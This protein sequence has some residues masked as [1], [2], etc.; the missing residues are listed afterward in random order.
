MALLGYGALAVASLL[1]GACVVGQRPPWANCLSAKALSGVEAQ[2]Q[3]EA[4]PKLRLLTI[5]IRAAARR[6]QRSFFL[7]T[8]SAL[9][10]QMQRL[11]HTP[12]LVPSA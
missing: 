7:M 2:D 1:S 12:G 10:G 4:Q 5:R 9:Q 3:A 11:S 6:K 8:K